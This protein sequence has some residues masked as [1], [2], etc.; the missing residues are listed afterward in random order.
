MDNLLS[1]RQSNEATLL[2][3]LADE[4]PAKDR[5]EVDQRL[6]VD[7]A[8]RA[9]LE[10]LRQTL[11][12]VDA[13]MAADDGRQMPDVDRAIRRTLAEM[14]Q[15]QVEAAARPAFGTPQGSRLP[16]PWWSYPLAAAASIVV[17]AAVFF[18]NMEPRGVTPSTMQER[19]AN[20][21]P[22]DVT[23]AQAFKGLTMNAADASAIAEELSATF[24]DSG[25]VF[26]DAAADSGLYAVQRQ[27][28]ALRESSQGSLGMMDIAVQ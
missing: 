6:Q 23:D 10:Q 5:A 1:Q 27:L 25:D 22:F 24:D 14:H 8:L 4:L 18:A 19:F 15:W 3:Y 20:A 11:E 17:A 12:Q 21:Q 13:V 7:G 2:M 28:D 9:Q 26:A 16:L